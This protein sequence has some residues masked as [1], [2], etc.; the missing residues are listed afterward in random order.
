LGGSLDAFLNV[1]GP[2]DRRYLLSANYGTLLPVYVRLAVFGVIAAV[3]FVRAKSTGGRL[4]ALWLPASLAGS[5]LTPKGYVHF[6][7]EAIPALALGIAMVAGGYR[8]RWLIVPAAAIALVVCG[9]AQMTVPEWQ[10]ALMTRQPPLLLRDS[11][12]FDLGYYTNWYGYATGSKSY[13]QYSTWFW[14]VPPR[15]RELARIQSLSRSPGDTLQV[16]GPQPW[17]Y[18][19]TNLLPGSPYLTSANNWAVAVAEER[20][21]TALRDGCADVVVVVNE[22]PKWQDALNAAGYVQ[23]DGGQWPTFQSSRPHHR[24]GERFS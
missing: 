17:L 14:D 13:N 12:G 4:I 18:F 10:T 16:I 20:V 6:V 21:L 15:E 9:L 3:A 2:I 11:V 24:C 1:V 8:I 19:D 23:V 7:H 5:T 22:L